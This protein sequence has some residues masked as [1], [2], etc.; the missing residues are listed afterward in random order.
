[1]LRYFFPT[2]KWPFGLSCLVVLF[3]FPAAGEPTSIECGS[4]LSN[5]LIVRQAEAGN[6]DA[7]VYLGKKLVQA[8][9]TNTQ[10]RQGVRYL[11][12]AVNAQHP[13]A[14]FTLGT[15]LISDAKAKNEERLGL[16]YVERSAELGHTRAAAFLGAHLM[17]QSQTED[18][19]NKAFVW[20]GRAASDGSVLAAMTLSELYQNG[21]HGVV[22]DR[23]SAALWRE[24]AGLLHQP[25]MDFSWQTDI[26]C[27]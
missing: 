22:Q 16:T 7:M 12:L 17:S 1:M 5:H 6:A 26:A 8:G 10:Q 19:R 21:L 18:Q 23:C 25:E 27:R 13:D 9:C 3:A 15:L 24:T 4:P 14:M 2:L 11:A 20:L